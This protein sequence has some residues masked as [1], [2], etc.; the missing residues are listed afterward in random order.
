[1]YYKLNERESS[2]TFKPYCKFQKNTQKYK[3]NKELQ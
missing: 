2:K 3:K 1:M